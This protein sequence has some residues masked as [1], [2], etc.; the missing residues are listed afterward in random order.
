MNENSDSPSPGTNVDM[1]QI[2]EMVRYLG[3]IGILLLLM[4]LMAALCYR[5]MSGRPIV[6]PKIVLGKNR[7]SNK[8][9]AL[10][11]DERQRQQQDSAMVRVWRH[12]NDSLAELEVQLV[13]FETDP[14]SAF[15]RPL[16]GDV[17]EPLTAEFHMALGRAQDARTDT[18]PA[19][20]TKV[21]DYGELVRA[22][23]LAWEAADRHAREVAVPATSDSERR[24][25]RQAEDVLRIALDERASIHERRIALARVETLIKGLTRIDPAART[26]LVLALDHEDRKEITS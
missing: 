3:T 12:H 6:V 11:R 18:L 14:W 23:T 19:T 21:D 25:L 4:V 26:K 15:R 10:S 22:A 13:E 2:D 24:R 8:P 5:L 20:R 16:L 1:A 17:R 9:A 7:E